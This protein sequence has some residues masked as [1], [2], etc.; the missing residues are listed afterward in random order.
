MTAVEVASTLD[1]EPDR[2]GL[3]ASS[4]MRLLGDPVPPLS[5]LQVSLLT[6]G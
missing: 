5:E 1:V 6:R 2:R 4:P 3:D